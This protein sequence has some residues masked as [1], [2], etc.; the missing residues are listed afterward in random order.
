MTLPPLCAVQIEITAEN[1]V[2]LGDVNDDKN[3]DNND[4][5]ALNN[6]LV[7]SH[8]AVVSADKSDL[9]NDDGLNVFDTIKLKRRLITWNTPVEKEKLIPFEWTKTGQ[10]RIRDGM[11]GKTL[12]CVF[13]GNPG[14]NLRLAFGYW[15]PNYVDSETGKT[16]K[17]FNDDSTFLGIYTFDETGKTVVPINVPVDAKSVEIILFNYYTTDESG[18][19][20]QLDKGEVGLEKIVE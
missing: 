6:Y 7:A 19:N 3:I 11:G 8:N 13:T 2:M 15:D 10:W 20:V 4:I 18:N 17:W 14:H 5:V 1:A 12:Q 9:T 16:G